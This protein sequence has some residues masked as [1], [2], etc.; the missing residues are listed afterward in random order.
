MPAPVGDASPSTFHE[1]LS[2]AACRCGHLPGAHMR[3][4]PIGTG[5]S[6]GGY[7]LEPSGPCTICGA[8]RCGA[9]SGPAPGRSPP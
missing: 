4:V 8:P 9:F 2:P 7:R 3:V 6:V 1:P 5:V